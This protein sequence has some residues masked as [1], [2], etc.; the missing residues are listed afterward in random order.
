MTVST[1]TTTTPLATVLSALRTS[2]PSL[3]ASQFASNASILYVPTGKGVDASVAGP[4]AVLEFF[5][6]W[7]KQNEW[8]GFKE[9]ILTT[10]FTRNTLVQESIVTIVH[11]GVCD[12][13]L[14]EVKPTRRS[15]TFPFVTIA[16]FDFEGKIQSLR[17]HWDQST[18]LRQIG[19]LPNSLFCKSNAS[20]TVL[21][22][23]GPKIIDRLKEVKASIVPFTL[24]T[25]S[26]SSAEVSYEPA[27]ATAVAAQQVAVAEVREELQEDTFAT[28]ARLRSQN[29]MS[30]LSFGT[31]ADS[32]TAL[33]GNGRSSSRV[34]Q[35]P[36]GKSS[37][38]FGTEEERRSV[39]KIDM[40]P[41]GPVAG[42]ATASPY[43]EEPAMQHRKR[44]PNATTFSF[45]ESGVIQS[46][47]HGNGRPSSRVLQRPGGMSNDIF[48]TE[49]MAAA[50][51]HAAS[52]VANSFDE[53]PLP[54]S[55]R[56]HVGAMATATVEE[57]EQQPQAHVANI[58]RR[59]P[60]AE[61]VSSDINNS[62]HMNGRSSSRVLRP[63]GGGGN[64]I[65]G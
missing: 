12:W 13:L 29:G 39:E 46:T 31:N 42:L 49:Q 24:E 4:K 37:D 7:V 63:P 45:G 22:V 19:A 11:E 64:I 35:R 58:R 5:K 26:T 65:F 25:T 57:I 54:T 50:K 14:P 8:I 9:E 6:T 3:A 51:L 60:N 16:E 18:V 44:D 59:D 1:T 52:V 55:T 34:L 47:L 17:F 21:P 40:K 53:A 32:A 36:G 30:H 61:S 48:G 2:N 10:V 23:L 56:Q 15:I 20:E 38:I 43:A 62:V 41:Q 33:H 27:S 28:A